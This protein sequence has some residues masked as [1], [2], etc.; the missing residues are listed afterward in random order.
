MRILLNGGMQNGKMAT[1]RCS[2]HEQVMKENENN[3]DKYG[4]KNNIILE[5]ED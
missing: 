5:R 2:C 4:S 3:W 1:E